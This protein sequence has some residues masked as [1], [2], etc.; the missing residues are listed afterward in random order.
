MKTG[1][2]F[3]NWNTA[4]NGSGTSYAPSATF[5]ISSSIILYA[6]WT[7]STLAITYHGN[8]ST[9]GSVP[10]DPLGPYANGATVT[11]LGNTGLLAKS[12]YVFTNW[13]TVANGSGTTYAPS[14]TFVIRSDTALYAQWTSTS[15]PIIVVVVTPQAPIASLEKPV[16]QVVLADATGES[17]VAATIEGNSGAKL[18]VSVT[19]PAGAITTGILISIAPA[20]T[21]ND[22]AAGAMTIKVS[23]TDSSG[24]I[25]SHFDKPLILNLGPVGARGIPMFSEDGIEWTPIQ[26]LSGTTLPDGIQEGYYIGVDGSTVILTRHLTYF[27]MKKYQ[28]SLGVSIKSLTLDAG[29]YTRVIA[30]GGSGKGAKGF[31]SLSPAVCSITKNGLLKAKSAGNCTIQATKAGYGTYLATSSP[32]INVTISKISQ[33]ALLVVASQVILKVGESSSLTVIG[34]SGIG[35]KRFATTTPTLC[36]VSPEGV[37]TGIAPG[38]CMVVVTKEGDALY[39]DALSVPIS[40][41]VKE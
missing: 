24:A 18:A 26:K 8:G 19:V 36:S 33:R 10:I 15:P 28:T 6:Q 22:A 16:T 35:L 13:N 14:T 39:L 7:P 34:G 4:A 37:V 11:V 38:I 2:I 32:P 41:A 27:G 3:T 31:I 5:T 20:M 9:G 21:S 12:G 29:K 25:I 1:S 30:S 23:A 17:I 40:M